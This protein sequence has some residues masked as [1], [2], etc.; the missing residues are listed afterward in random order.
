MPQIRANA[1]AA[2][3]AVTAA[4][5]AGL[6]WVDNSSP[7][8]R[9]RGRPGHFHYVDAAGRGVS[10][11]ATLQRIA[12]AVIPP[13]WTDVW[14]S[15]VPNGH[16]QATGRD[17]RRRKQYRYHQRWREVRDERKYHRMLAFGRALPRIR[18]RVAHD[19]ALPDLPR[20][21][22][23]AAVVRLLDVTFIRVGNDE[24]ARENASYGLTTLRDRHVDVDGEQIRFRFRG[25]SGKQH[26]V[27]IRDRRL[28]RIVDRCQDIPGEALFEYLDADG[29]AQG[30]GADDVNDY[31]REIAGD[32]FTSK[33]FR[34][35]AGTVL[36]LC[37]LRDL[38]G[39]P[40][41]S[42]A[43]RLVTEAIGRVSARLGNTP[44]VC[45][46]CYVHPDVIEA[47]ADGRLLQLRLRASPRSASGLRSEERA[48]LRLLDP[49]GR[50]RR[51]AARAA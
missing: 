8:I 5:A 39:A 44:A 51:S 49:R 6:R 43:R 47:F 42:Q 29:A 48:L 35:W 22:V 18:R 45:R 7:G 15:P 32:A 30:V 26:V 17:V 38:S 37:E 21:R 31:L 33:D 24:Y 23:L 41:R 10:D 14:I 28:A 19:L 4:R 12:D 25:K 36:A 34:T 27:S 16:I 40:S 2:E 46:R 50:T 1:G 11:A 3:D 9:R 13:A 20:E